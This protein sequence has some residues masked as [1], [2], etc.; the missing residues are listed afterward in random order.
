MTEQKCVRT[1]DTN[2]FGINETR[3][4]C[5]ELTPYLEEGWRVVFIT[6]K[7]TYIEYIIEREVD[8]GKMERM[9]I[10]K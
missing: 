6:P 7:A 5:E 3:V 9:E 2:E 8:N 1:Y 10:E 4:C